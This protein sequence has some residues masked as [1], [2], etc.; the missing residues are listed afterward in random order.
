[1]SGRRSGRMSGGGI[2]GGIRISGRDLEDAEV[3]AGRD[4]G[5]LHCCDEGLVLV[6]RFTSG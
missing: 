6:R 4:E 5:G 3:G 2:R 1:M